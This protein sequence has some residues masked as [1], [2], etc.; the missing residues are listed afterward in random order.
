[1]AKELSIHDKKNLAVSMLLDLREDY[2]IDYRRAR[3]MG[4]D[5][6]DREYIMDSII[7]TMKS[8]DETVA[9]LQGSAE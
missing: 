2:A 8:I 7:K 1:M 4:D 5:L 3:D 6:I 9:R